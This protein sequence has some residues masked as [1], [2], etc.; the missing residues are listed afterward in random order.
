MAIEPWQ[1][2]QILDTRTG[3]ILTETSNPDAGVYLGKRRKHPGGFVIVY[4]SEFREAALLLKPYG[5]LPICLWN[6]L[7]T[8][9]EIGTGEILVDT[10]DLAKMLKT[11]R[12][13]V[14]K[15]VKTLVDLGLIKHV[16]DEI[17]SK[18]KEGK[19]FKYQMNPSIMWKGKETERQN[20][21]QI[22]QGGKGKQE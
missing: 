5:A 7:F 13:N 22:L 21:I 12:P 20:L 9:V 15:A 10:T 11:H 19:H 18:K 16:E 2:I 14:S 8:K 6:I 4:E 17:K 1:R 3:E